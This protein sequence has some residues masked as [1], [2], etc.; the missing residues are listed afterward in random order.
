[1]TVERSAVSR[2]TSPFLSDVGLSLLVKNEEDT[3]WQQAT[4]I[5]KPFTANV[6]YLTV[7]GSILVSLA[8][9]VA[10]SSARGRK[11]SGSGYLTMD[12]AR[13]YWPSSLASSLFA[14]FSMDKAS[15]RT[16]GGA[17]VNLTWCLFA[18][19]WIAT[20]TAN[21]AQIMIVETTNANVASLDEMNRKGLKACV[22]RGA[23]YAAHM[24]ELFPEIGLVEIDPRFPAEAVQKL[25]DGDCDA[26]VDSSA[27]LELIKGLRAN[28]DAELV[29]PA[30]P[31]RYGDM[32]MAVGVR[33]GLED[34]GVRDALSYWI[35]K[36][37]YCSASDADPAC[38]GKWN[39]DDMWSH[40]AEDH[41]VDDK[42]FSGNGKRIGMTQFAIPLALVGFVCAAVL[43]FEATQPP[44]A[45][46]L[47]SCLRPRLDLL[48][49]LKAERS[50][51]REDDATVF[52][53]DAF[54]AALRETDGPRA[55]LN[56][57]LLDHFLHSDT[58]AWAALRDDLNNLER[59]RRVA[60]VGESFARVHGPTLARVLALAERAAHDTLSRHKLK[61]ATAHASPQTPMRV[62]LSSS[63]SRSGRRLMKNLDTAGDA[64]GD[65]SGPAAA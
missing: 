29:V 44:A 57:A 63:L 10:E 22:K 46:R 25:E 30:Q 26:Y 41:C 27:T 2:F 51:W 34:A 49:A 47:R 31:L 60:H 53:M 1:M 20:Y 54:L 37:R 40:W 14:L 16:R 65:E 36:L 3:I 59:L 56:A 5:F 7:A 39:M 9:W 21:L 23:A 18:V 19:I 52:D 48:A 17:V 38:R 15:T 12:S 35:T 11:A 55:P 13:R 8:L 4:K 45:A 58:A 24:P 43:F 64:D 28:C 6:W 61:L 62:R 50:W 42:T 33:D 32:D